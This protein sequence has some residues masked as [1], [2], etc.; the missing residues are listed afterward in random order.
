M[1]TFP[2]WSKNLNNATIEDQLIELLE[3]SREKFLKK[4]GVGRL[5]TTTFDNKENIGEKSTHGLA[6]KTASFALFLVII[7]IWLLVYVL[8]SYLTNMGQ[9]APGHILQ[10]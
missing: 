5:L 2:V 6:Y 4:G 7:L 1:I 8:A 9:S 10:N 3:I